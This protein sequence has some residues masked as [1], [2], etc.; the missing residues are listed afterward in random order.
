M[1]ELIAAWEPQSPDD[2]QH[3]IQWAQNISQALAPY[4]FKYISLLDEQEQER[5]PPAF[6][7]N[8]ERL[9]DLKRRYDPMIYF[10]RRLDISRRREHWSTPYSKR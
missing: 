7:P 2:E 3:Y 8:Y 6:G 9:L 5:V 10:A 4:A 1:V